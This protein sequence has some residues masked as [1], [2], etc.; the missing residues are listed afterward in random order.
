VLSISAE[1]APRRPRIDGDRDNFGA[2]PFEARN[3]VSGDDSPAFRNQKQLPAFAVKLCKQVAV[4]SV[5]AEAGGF[6][7][8]DTVQVARAETADLWARRHLLSFILAH[9]RAP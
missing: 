2:L 5:D 1:A 9:L 7:L 4:V 3:D 8:G 6:D